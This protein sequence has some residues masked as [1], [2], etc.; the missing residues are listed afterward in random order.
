MLFISFLIKASGIGDPL[1]RKITSASYCKILAIFTSI[2]LFV[3]L[4]G[5]V[6]GDEPSVDNLIPNEINGWKAETP[7]GIYDRKTLFDYIDGGAEVYLAY[8]FQKMLARRFVKENE[9]SITLDIFD[10]GSPEDAFG[11]Y[12]FEQDG[13]SVGIGNDSEYAAGLL[14]FWKGKYFVSILADKESPD[15]RK[16]VMALGRIVA[17][18]I[19]PAGSKPEV[20]SL[21]PPLNLIK[22]SIRYFHKKSGLDYHYF[23]ADKNI[24]NLDEHTNVVLAEYAEKKGKSKLLVVR[25]PDEDGSVAA[26]RSFVKAYMPEAQN[27]GILKTEDGKWVAVKRCGQYLLAVF[28]APTRERASE[29]MA[30][31]KMRWERVK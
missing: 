12:S 27:T 10:M 25:Y 26:Y 13:K 30:A 11:V 15:A 28:E 7:D 3:I 6:R 16:A 8:G 18:N 5:V 20:V 24:L 23:L 14:R 4:A 17:S 2:I 29:L 1:L 19:Q 9:P 21:L 31:V 22:T